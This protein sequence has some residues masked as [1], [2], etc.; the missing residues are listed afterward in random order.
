MWY[1]RSRQ[2][3]LAAA[4]V[5]LLTAASGIAQDSS[6]GTTTRQ[7]QMVP[8]KAYLNKTLDAKKAKQ[9]DPVT[10]KLQESV[11]IPDAKELPN[12]TLLIGHIDQ[13]QASEK[14]S[15]SSIQVT[16]DKAQLKDGTQIPIKATVMQINAP[17][18]GGAPFQQGG[19]PQA[20]GSAAPSGGSSRGMA[21]TPGASAP[22]PAGTP[23]AGQEGLN[24]VTLQ[25][26][27]HEQSSGTFV[28]KGKNV[29]LAEGTQMEFALAIVPPNTSMQ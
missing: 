20:G 28:A 3:L 12:N 25:S 16:F 6:N 10:A 27:I 26:D 21:P 14:K 7:I 24:G 19:A 11:K 29:H 22:A 5:V 9:G 2:T 4:S 15:D 8:A 17:S 13:V 23:D 18:E 1:L